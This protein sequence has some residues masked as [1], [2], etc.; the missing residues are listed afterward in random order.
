M[1]LGTVLKKV[2]SGAYKT[3][4]A[5]TE[6]LEL[7]WANCLVYNSPI[8][9]PLRT[10]AEALRTKAQ[11]LL[12]YVSEPLTNGIIGAGVAKNPNRPVLRP[13]VSRNAPESFV[14][15]SAAERRWLMTERGRASKTEDESVDCLHEI[16]DQP[17][18]ISSPPP[19]PQLV[20]VAWPERPA[21]IR[22]P[23]KMWN[24]FEIGE[25]AHEDLSFKILNSEM[26]V[27]GLPALPF[28][29]QSTRKQKNTKRKNVNSSSN[30]TSSGLARSIE[31]NVKTL[32]EIKK[33]HRKISDLV[34]GNYNNTESGPVP[35]AEDGA[36]SKTGKSRGDDGDTE[37]E[38]EDTD[39][40]PQFFFQNLPP[41]ETFNSCM[42]SSAGHQAMRQIV[43]LLI[44]HVGF[45][46]A[47]TGALNCLTEVVVQYLSNIGRT[48]HYF[49]DRFSSSL[50]ASEM[51]YQTLRANGIGGLDE[52]E[53]YVR[54]T[55]DRYSTKLNEILRKLQIGYVNGLAG[56]ASKVVGDDDFFSK[57]G[58]AMMTGEFTNE[59]G[60]DF[61][62][63]RE[64]GLDS[65]LGVSSLKIPSRLFYGRPKTD[66]N[67]DLTKPQKHGLELEPRFVKPIEFVEL[68][69][70]WIGQQIGLLQPVYK[71]RCESKDFGLKDD[72]KVIKLPK[73][74]RPKVP[75]S[76][77]IPIKRRTAPANNDSQASK[78]KKI[79]QQQEQGQA[80]QESKFLS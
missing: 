56:P 46:A 13:G 73:I 44:A 71:A 1:D 79:E 43:S 7:I 11:N 8:N 34:I 9:H 49:A 30:K 24:W 48:L 33:V 38:E 80:D 21:L 28:A 55:T 59:L 27:C 63:L 2:K 26:V 20:D 14:S 19:E 10:A 45:D 64:L 18:A 57:D 77:K 31:Q 41:P 61:F 62:G 53:G 78:K 42:A 66:T 37:D 51:I 75:P 58:E 3:K 50:S 15:I 68:K 12:K 17:M 40:S 47:Q 39:I 32:W 69:R 22:A 70:E 76:G 25:N 74:F 72:D 36:D 16:E 23:D 6:D 67:S 4:A 54:D 35:L 65:E 5:F 29:A 60:E 52:L